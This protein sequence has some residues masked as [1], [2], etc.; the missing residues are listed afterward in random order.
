MNKQS[1][2]FF[3]S[4]NPLVLICVQR[5]V[6]NLSSMLLLVIVMHSVKN[7]ALEIMFANIRV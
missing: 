2:L 7:T 1:K 6:L 4:P 5:C 3:Y